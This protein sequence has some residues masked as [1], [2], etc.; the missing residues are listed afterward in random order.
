VPQFETIEQ[1]QEFLALL[2]HKAG[3]GEL[4]LQSALDISTLVKNWIISKQ[5]GIELDLK[6]ATQIN[7][8]T[9][10]VI[11]IEGGLPGLPGTE[12]TMPLNGQQVDPNKLVEHEPAVPDP[13][14]RGPGSVSAASPIPPTSEVPDA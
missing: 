12:I 11:R 4:E 5:S 2:S 3:A 14:A 6:V 7:G 8:A 9:P 10:E 13:P 1:A